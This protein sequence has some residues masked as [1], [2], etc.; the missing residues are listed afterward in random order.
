MIKV[1][2]EFEIV[3]QDKINQGK[4]Q[5]YSHRVA[6]GIH[7][8]DALINGGM[9]RGRTY[10]LAG[11][12]GTG[13][14]IFGIQYIYNGAK[15]YGENGIYVTF[16]ETPDQLRR[17]MLHFGWDLGKLENTRQLIL[18]DASS[19]RIGLSSQENYIVHRPFTLDSL[20]SDID[21]N[22][23]TIDARRIVIDC[24]D[25]AELHAKSSE[26]Y[27]RYVFRLSAILKTLECT[28]LLISESPGDGRISRYGV[29]EYVT[30]GIIYL[31]STLEENR[32]IRKVEVVKARGTSHS[33]TVEEFEIT[34]NGIEVQMY[35][36]RDRALKRLS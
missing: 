29:E 33:Q 3:N 30:D 24:L 10:L 17:D 1:D 9:L 16:E 19:A 36:T 6:S 7:G 8:F 34:S 32:R 5:A 15:I 21:K 14:T 25:A 27:R 28:S 12:P 23:E 20:L 11:P 13:K 4:K 18:V 26:E 22:I 31:S 2:R 35:R